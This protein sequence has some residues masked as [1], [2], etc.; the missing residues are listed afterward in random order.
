MSIDDGRLLVGAEHLVAGAPQ[1]L[2]EPVDRAS[3]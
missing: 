2:D 3:I 1:N